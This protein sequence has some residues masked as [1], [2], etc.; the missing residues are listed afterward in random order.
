MVDPKM[1]SRPLGVGGLAEPSMTSVLSEEPSSPVLPSLVVQSLR[2]NSKKSSTVLKVGADLRGAL[3]QLLNNNVSMAI[4]TQA[5]QLEG[6]SRT[7]WLTLSDFR[8]V[9]FRFVIVHGVIVVLDIDETFAEFRVNN[10]LHPPRMGTGAGTAPPTSRG[11][12][13]FDSDAVFVKDSVPILP[14]KSVVSHGTEVS[15]YWK[16]SLVQPE[17]ENA[18]QH[19]GSP[20]SRVRPKYWEDGTPKTEQSNAAGVH[21]DHYA[22]DGFLEDEVRR[23][24]AVTVPAGGL[25]GMLA[26]GSALRAARTANLK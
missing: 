22:E 24:G 8:I 17:A 10:L 2:S 20:I 7:S 4:I 11:A 1:N 3:I 9:Y 21:E 5:L 6:L 12:D 26:Q 18:P 15:S 25:G 13:A 19:N 16:S 23:A 14:M